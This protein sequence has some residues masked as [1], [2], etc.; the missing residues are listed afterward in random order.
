LDEAFSVASLTSLGSLC[1]FSCDLSFGVM[2]IMLLHVNGTS[3]LRSSG[4]GGGG[5]TCCGL[6]GCD[7]G[8]GVVGI[9]LL[10]VT[11]LDVD[12]SSTL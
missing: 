9:A 5:T 1:L 10:N 11:L 3:T 12:G 7:L 6:F 4:G 2:R 8:F